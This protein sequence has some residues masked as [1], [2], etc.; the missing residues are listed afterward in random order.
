MP[1]TLMV[2]LL[3]ISILNG[4][5]AVLVRVVVFKIWTEEEADGSPEHNCDTRVTAFV[6]GEQ[7]LHEQ[8]SM[9]AQ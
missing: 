5:W 1:R 9:V 2:R 4:F 3:F 8:K 6:D 7:W